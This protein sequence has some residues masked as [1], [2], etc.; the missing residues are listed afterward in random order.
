ME[1]K[2]IE[3]LIEINEKRSKSADIKFF[4]ACLLLL[5]SLVGN[6]YQA[7]MTTEITVESN[8][9]FEQSDNNINQVSGK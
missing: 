6:I 8:P 4:V 9:L 2:I 5:I 7:T 1:E 3:R